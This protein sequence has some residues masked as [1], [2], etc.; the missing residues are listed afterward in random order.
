M[1]WTVIPKIALKVLGIRLRGTRQEIRRRQALLKYV[2]RDALLR[3]DTTWDHFKTC[4][5]VGSI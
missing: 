5:K 4:V 1:K 2:T 3:V